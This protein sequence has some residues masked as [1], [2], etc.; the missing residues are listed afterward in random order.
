LLERLAIQAD[1]LGTVLVV[2][3]RGSTGEPLAIDAAPPRFRVVPGAASGPAAARNRGWRASDA[4]WIAFLDDDVVPPPGWADALRDD[5]AACGARVAGTQGRIRVPLPVGRRPSD[6]ERNVAGLAGARFATADMAYRRAALVAVGGFD[7]RFPRAY[8]ED[9]DLAL[10]VIEAGYEISAGDRVV[11]HPPG[12]IRRFA[13]LRQ[14]AGN[15]DDA[16]MRR[17]HG[18]RWRPRIGG[19]RPLLA[20]HALTTASGFG[21]IIAAAAGRRRTGVTLGAVWL[22]LTAAFA[23]RRIAPGPRDPREVA[24]MIVTSVLIPPLATFHRVRGEIQWRGVGPVTALDA[25]LFDRDGTV[26]DDVP[27]NGDPDLVRL[28][29]GAREAI[30]SVRCAGIP[31]GIVSNQSGIARGLLTENAVAAVNRRIEELIGPVPVWAVCPH[32]PDDGCDCRKPAPGLIVQA[33]RR[34]GVLPERCAVIGDI[35]SDVEAARAA[36]ARAILVPTE[37]TRAEEVAAAP[38]VALSLTEAVERLL[39]KP[40]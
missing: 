37:V 1:G 18:P 2:D 25:V 27:Y 34:L 21:G 17:L 7:E 10:R 15:A 31:F 26:V 3:D 22:A 4:E 9:A 14:Q 19:G 11:D 29:P 39:G 16:L 13:S 23:Y 5:I 6:A 38:E 8:R 30:A 28:R 32:G 35:G 24:D 36:G 40:S 20:R 33:A 12:P